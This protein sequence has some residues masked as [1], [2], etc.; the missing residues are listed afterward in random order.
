MTAFV[1]LCLCVLNYFPTWFLQF[2]T[3]LHISPWAICDA[4]KMTVVLRIWDMI[5]CVTGRRPV[6][7]GIWMTVIWTEGD[8]SKRLVVFHASPLCS[9]WGPLGLARVLYL[10]LLWWRGI[11]PLDETM[12]SVSQVKWGFQRF[13]S[14]GFGKKSQQ[15]PRWQNCLFHLY[16]RKH[17]CQT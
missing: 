16:W 14:S 11:V 12:M 17:N 7:A 2:F 9:L 1:R 8:G 6:H 4:C 10:H 13:I 15:G 3:K 5:V